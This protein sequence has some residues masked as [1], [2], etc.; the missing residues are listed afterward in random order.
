MLHI[1]KN[2]GNFISTIAMSLLAY[3]V[4]AGAG[5]NLSIS[6]DQE[7]DAS[8]LQL[9]SGGDDGKT[10]KTMPAET[11]QV[12]VQQNAGLNQVSPDSHFIFEVPVKIKTANG[13]FGPE[14]G[15]YEGDTMQFKIRCRVNPRNSVDTDHHFGDWKT[16]HLGPNGDYD[17]TVRVG[18]QVTEGYAPHYKFHYNSYNDNG[19]YG[20][21]LRPAH[22]EDGVMDSDNGN[23]KGPT[24][25]DLDLGAAYN[26]YLSGDFEYP[27]DAYGEPN[28]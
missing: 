21:Y 8:Q 2:F 25:S 4:I 12:M 22:P 23:W 13:K 28:F 7:T 6:P 24:R 11:Q 9:N 5:G 27:D 14:W 1:Q 17:G 3:P 20:C 16:I 10:M 15:E 26:L 19:D 18:V